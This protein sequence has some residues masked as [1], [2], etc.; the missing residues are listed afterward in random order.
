MASI[1]SMRLM[2]HDRINAYLQTRRLAEASGGKRIRHG[3][4][5]ADVAGDPTR[6]IWHSLGPPA[7]SMSTLQPNAPS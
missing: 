1:V 2:T 5:K 4:A 3:L 6:A 7:L